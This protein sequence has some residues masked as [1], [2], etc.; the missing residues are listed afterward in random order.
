MPLGCWLYVAVHDPATVKIA[1]RPQH[2]PPKSVQSKLAF[3]S[4]A[5]IKHRQHIHILYIHTYPPT[6]DAY[7]PP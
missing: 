2:L 3:V 7:G 4:S 5:E 6:N 1:H